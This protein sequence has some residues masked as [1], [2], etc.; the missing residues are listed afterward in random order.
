MQAKSPEKAQ[1]LARI[2]KKKLD[3]DRSLQ[4][5]IRLF[6]N[7]KKKLDFYKKIIFAFYSLKEHAHTLGRSWKVKQ[8]FF[9]NTARSYGHNA[10]LGEIGGVNVKV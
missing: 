4:K 6:Q 2:G 7:L 1:T 5:K 3:F 10:I 9:D 8:W